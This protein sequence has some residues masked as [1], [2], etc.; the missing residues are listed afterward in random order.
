MGNLLRGGDPNR[1]FILSALAFREHI[2]VIRFHN[3][4][5]TLLCFPRSSFSIQ[6]PRRVM[7]CSGCLL[8]SN[9]RDISPKLYLIAACRSS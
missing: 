5:I 2:L 8:I 7:P 4:H 9:A 6:F 3:N 1:Q